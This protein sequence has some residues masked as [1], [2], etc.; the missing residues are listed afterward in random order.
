[1]KEITEAL[2]FESTS[3]SELARK[4]EGGYKEGYIIKHVIKQPSPSYTGSVIIVME[5]TVTK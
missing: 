5:R 2:V 3:F 1:M 4:I